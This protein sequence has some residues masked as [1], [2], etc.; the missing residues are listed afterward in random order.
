[1][2]S[3]AAGGGEKDKIRF[4]LKQ[5]DRWDKEY[6]KKQSRQYNDTSY[7]NGNNSNS[8]NNDDGDTVDDN[9]RK[10]NDSHYRDRADERRRNINR[11]GD[12]DVEAAAANLG[13]EQSKFMGGSIEHTHFVKGLDYVLLQKIRNENQTIT[14]GTAS[15]ATSTSFNM[16]E[17]SINIPDSAGTTELGSRLKSFLLY[18]RN[19][20][21]TTQFHKTSYEFQVDNESMISDI[22]GMH[23]LQPTIILKSAKDV[24]DF[25]NRCMHTY[26]NQSIIGRMHSALQPKIRNSSNVA[27]NDDISS[28]PKSSIAATAKVIDDIYGD[29][30]EDVGKYVPA[31]ST[32]AITTTAITATG[33]TATH[34]KVKIGSLF[35]RASEFVRA[36]T[37]NDDREQLKSLLQ[38]QYVR[39]EM[40]KEH[41]LNTSNRNSI[42]N[43]EMVVEK[44]K[45]HRSIFDDDSNRRQT[46]NGDAMNV[47]GGSY[48]DQ[49]FDDD[50][51]DTNSRKRSKFSK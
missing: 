11:D 19:Q 40:Q 43:D 47:Y 2:S 13:V 27:P 48:D 49:Y 5:I 6:K 15:T 23:D 10:N 28:N 38:A 29:I 18:S 36:E 37:T 4:D 12:N 41:Q 25:D 46:S 31:G 14:S 30:F 9:H 21:V 1:M 39:E 8:T 34:T 45:V 22:S 50:D 20:Y 7:H 3:Q 44:N 33:N 51:D 16:K 35:G 42:N 32:T 26:V 24:D 17:K